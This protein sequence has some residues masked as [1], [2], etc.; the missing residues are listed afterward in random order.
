MGLDLKGLEGL[1]GLDRQLQTIQIVRPFA[2]QRKVQKKTKKK[3]KEGNAAGFDFRV[4]INRR[5]LK[6][7]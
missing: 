4:D 2:D 3:Q 1:L 6:L 5:L 7:D